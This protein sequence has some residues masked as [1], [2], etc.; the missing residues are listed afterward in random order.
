[1][2]N[3]IKAHVFR[4]VEVEPSRTEFVCV[5]VP[6]KRTVIQ[7]EVRVSLPRED[8]EALKKFLAEQKV[9]CLRSVGFEVSVAYKLYIALRDAFKAPVEPERR[10]V[11]SANIR[12]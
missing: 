12:L 1:M 3:E 5:R 10:M 9:G 2:S 11:H 7:D 8:A 4:V 6:E